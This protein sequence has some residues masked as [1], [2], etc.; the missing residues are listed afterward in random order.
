M[1]K[2]IAYIIAGLMTICAVALG[3]FAPDAGANT[4]DAVF[5]AVLSQQGIKSS[6]GSDNLIQYGHLVCAMRSA[7]ASDDGVISYLFRNTGLNAFDSGF[8]VGASEAAYCPVFAP[9]DDGQ[10]VS[11]VS[12]SQRGG[13]GRR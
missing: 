2:R 1:R 12:Y 7:G 4:I 13:R 8:F 11:V 5:L 10:G 9:S 3:G 6:G